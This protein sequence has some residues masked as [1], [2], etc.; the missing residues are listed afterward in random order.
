MWEM[1]EDSLNSHGNNCVITSVC[2]IVK[3]R[4]HSGSSFWRSA[5]VTFTSCS[6]SSSE[7]LTGSESFKSIGA[8]KI[9][10]SASVCPSRTC[11][12]SW[13]SRSRGRGPSPASG[14]GCSWPG[15]SRYPPWWPASAEK[16]PGSECGSPSWPHSE[17]GRE[18]EG[19]R[20]GENP[21]CFNPK[22]EREVT[23]SSLFSQWFSSVPVPPWFSSSIPSKMGQL[24]CLLASSWSKQQ[25]TDSAVNTDESGCVSEES[26]DPDHDTSICCDT[27]GFITFSFR[28]TVIM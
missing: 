10:T 3:A 23:S 2:L 19:G 6:D 22:T 1:I 12:S 11:S 24:K 8:T 5:D 13:R 27:S 15:T 25:S 28:K 21:N 17:G 16:T 4:K 26:G 9:H 18:S 7:S 14:P 20:R